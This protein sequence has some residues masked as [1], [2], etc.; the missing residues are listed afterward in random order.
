MN[1]GFKRIG[2]NYQEVNFGIVYLTILKVIRLSVRFQ[3]A[4]YIHYW[5]ISRRGGRQQESSL[6]AGSIFLLFPVKEVKA[7]AHMS[8]R[9]IWPELILV[10]SA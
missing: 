2:G 3:V 5:T 7:K 8:Q 6:F 9:P 4:A 1:K 10:S